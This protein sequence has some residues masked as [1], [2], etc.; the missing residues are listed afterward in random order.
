V[1]NLQNPHDATQLEFYEQAITYA[2]P[3]PYPY[4]NR[5]NYYRTAGDYGD[6]V[7]N[8]YTTAFELVPNE[9]SILLDRART[10][11]LRGDVI[12]AR[13]DFNVILE[14]DPT[15]VNAY[16]GRATGYHS[17]GDIQAAIDDLLTAIRIDPESEQAYYNL[18]TILLR[19]RQ[20]VPALY[21]FN[22]ALEINPD[23]QAA[24]FSRSQIYES[25]G[26]FNEQEI[27]AYPNVEALITPF[28]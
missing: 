14:R 4:R 2:N 13:T 25:M 27:M 23:L 7:I 15:Y 17:L 5:A 12:F 24:L 20:Y 3:Y 21:A 18:G 1:I 22:R 9:L 26:G 11:S 19:E 28:P 10:F 8:D 16:I 6:H